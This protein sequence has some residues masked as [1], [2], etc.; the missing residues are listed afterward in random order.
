MD[1]P[2][3]TEPRPKESDTERIS[4]GALPTR[5]GAG[6]LGAAAPT[7]ASPLGLRA[8]RDERLILY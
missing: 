8:H 4:R 5:A 1:E 7:W 2:S 3:S 6:A